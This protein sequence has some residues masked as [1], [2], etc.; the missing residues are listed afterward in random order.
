M[1]LLPIVTSSESLQIYQFVVFIVSKPKGRIQHRLNFKALNVFSPNVCMEST[2]SIIASHHQ[3]DFLV[4]VDIKNVYLHV[5]ILPAHHCY[6]HFTLGDLIYQFVALLL[7]L[8]SAPKVLT[9]VLA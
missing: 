5:P 9:L 7:S 6:L 1:E 3:G 2:R 8:C 4:S